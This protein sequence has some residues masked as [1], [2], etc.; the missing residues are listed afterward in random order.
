MDD[1]GRDGGGGKLILLVDTGGGGAGRVG[2][3]N[4]KHF[5]DFCFR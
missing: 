1:V 4:T 3:A 2:P 5:C